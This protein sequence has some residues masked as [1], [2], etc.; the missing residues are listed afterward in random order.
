MSN[1]ANAATGGTTTTNNMLRGYVSRIEN[2]EEQKKDIS[3]DIKDVYSEAEGEGFDKKA[4]R[5]LIRLR[6]QD[7]AERENLDAVVE[8]YEA[9]LESGA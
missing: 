4:L 8:T 3:N 6:K 7:K 5:T 9:A 1:T 2:L